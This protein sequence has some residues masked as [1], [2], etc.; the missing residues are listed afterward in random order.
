MDGSTL[1]VMESEAKKA[2]KGVT[3][4]TLKLIAIITMLIDHTAAT[5]LDRTL[6]ARGIGGL[7]NSN[8]QAAMDFINDNAVIYGVDMIMRLIGRIA[9]PIFCFLLVEGLVHTH[10]KWKYALRL[11]IFALISEIPFDLAFK[12]KLFDFS[13]QNV[14]FTLLIGLLVMM[15]FDLVR[16]K[17]GEKKWIPVIAIG[18]SIAIGYSVTYL[19]HRFIQTINIYLGAAQTGMIFNL[20]NV[21][22]LI[23]GVVSCILSLLIYGLMIRKVSLQKASIRFADLLVLFVGMLFAQFLKT[24]YSAFGIL[25]IAVVYGLRKSSFKAILGGCITLTIMNLS[26]ITAFFALIP[27]ALY[28]GKRGLNL[29]YVFYIFYP[30]HLLILYLIC[31]F[32]GIV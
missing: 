10:N 1:T 19:L 16:E 27:A 15:G 3:G 20:S 23:I 5:I 30:A 11:G 28:N 26:E 24:D 8:T 22:F 7:G 6:I 17:L 14:F 9:F 21:V 31:Y 13:Y 12:S 29:K 4:S 18:G 2:R 32:M 25:T